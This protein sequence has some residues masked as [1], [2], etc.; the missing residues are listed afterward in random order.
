MSRFLT[1]STRFASTV[2]LSTLLSGCSDD[3]DA[4]YPT[5]YQ[6]AVETTA[7]HA[8]P[9][10]A[11]QRFVAFFESL[12]RPGVTDRVVEL[13][14]SPLY[15]SDTLMVTDD[16]AA[17]TRHFERLHARGAHID[18]SLYDAL[19]GA[20][21]DLYLRW[22]MSVRLR[23]D[24]ATAA[25]TIGMTQLRFDETGRISLQQD[26]WD[27]AEGVYRRIPLLGSALRF[28]DARIAAEP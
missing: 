14:A 9:A 21:G 23:G 26:F 4:R 6:R 17:L 15:F 24:P 5:L 28:V 2:A 19:V 11:A 7:A 25:A 12:D 10:D 3:A 22:R 13:Y 8:V 16:R 20:N 27:S 1:L 18:V